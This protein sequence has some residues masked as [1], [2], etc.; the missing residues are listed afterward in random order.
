[1]GLTIQ[2]HSGRYAHS[3]DTVQTRSGER[4]VCTLSRTKRQPFDNKFDCSLRISF[5]APA[6]LHQKPVVASASCPQVN[7]FIEVN[8]V[9]GSTLQA[10][11]TTLSA[12]RMSSSHS[13]VTLSFD[14]LP[15]LSF[16]APPTEPVNRCVCVQRSC[17]CRLIRLNEIIRSVLF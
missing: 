12:L 7:L 9:R 17:V 15:A 16:P 1:M 2:R 13:R 6:E 5:W 10:T 3:V 4:S 8:A 11:P 14:P